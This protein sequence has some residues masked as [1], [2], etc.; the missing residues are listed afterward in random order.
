MPLITPPFLNAGAY[1]SPTYDEATWTPNL[2]FGTPSG[3]VDLAYLPDTRD[4]FLVRNGNL[5]N[6]FFRFQ[7]TA[8]GSSN[9]DA[10]ISGLPFRFNTNG[11]YGGGVVSYQTGMLLLTNTTCAF[12]IVQFSN[13]PLLLSLRQ[14]DTNVGSADMTNTSQMIGVGSFVAAGFIALPS[15]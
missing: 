3:I 15:I 4:G 7:L 9:G 5:I 13:L 14:A 8:K 2:F 10:F 11:D 12:R 1:L 6:I